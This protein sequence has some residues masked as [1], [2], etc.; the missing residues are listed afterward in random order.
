MAGNP[1]AKLVPYVKKYGMELYITTGVL[2]FLLRTR[3]AK[4]TYNFVYSKN[5]FERR[6]A[7][8]EMK[9]YCDNHL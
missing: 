5:D 4:Y 9:S 1:L 8:E 3:N 6:Q 7:L 2:A